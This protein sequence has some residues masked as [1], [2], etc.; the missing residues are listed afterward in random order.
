L[1]SRDA[2]DLGDFTLKPGRLV[3]LAGS[4]WAGHALEWPVRSSGLQRPFAKTV[5]AAADF[6]A[7]LLNSQHTIP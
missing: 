2:F 3:R 7:V 5:V 1:I 6:V 4:F